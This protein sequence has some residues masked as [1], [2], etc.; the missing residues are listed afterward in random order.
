V[1]GLAGTSVRLRDDAG[2]ETVVLLAN[3]LAHPDLE[4]TGGQAHLHVEPLGGLDAL[5]AEVR[6]GIG[7]GTSLGGGWGMNWGRV[8]TAAFVAAIL[9]TAVACQP[10]AT[11]GWR[12]ELVSV[13][14]AGTGTGNGDSTDPVFSPDGTK[15]AFVSYATDLG[16]E[17]VTRFVT[18]IYVRDLTSNEVTLVSVSAAGDD[19]GNG[20]STDPVFS[21]D[22]TKIA[23]VSVARNLGPA[24]SDRPGD[25]WDQD[26]YVRDLEAGTTTLASVNTDGTDSGAFRSIDPVFNPANG[27][28]LVF[29]SGADDLVPDDGDGYN[30]DIFLRDLSAG[31]TTLLTVNVPDLNVGDGPSSDPAF[32]G[33]GSKLAFQSGANLVPGF[34]RSPGPDVF[35]RDMRTGVTTPVSW[36][37]DHTRGANASSERPVL[38][39]DGSMVAFTSSATD[40]AGGDEDAPSGAQ[41][42]IFVRDLTT[43]TTTLASVGEQYHAD[44]ATFS[45]DGTKLAYTSGVVSI[46]RTEEGLIAT[47][48]PDV[49]DSLENPTFSPDSR[50]LLARTRSS[51]DPRES[52]FP[53]N[54]VY[55]IDLGNGHA[56]LI[57]SNDTQTEGGDD[58]SGRWL[59]PSVFSPD[60]RSIAFESWAGDLTADADNATADIYITRFVEAF[61]HADLSLDATASDHGGALRPALRRLDR[62]PALRC[63]HPPARR[64]GAAH[65]RRPRGRRPRHHTDQRGRHRPRSDAR[66]CGRQQRRGHERRGRRLSRRRP[67][68]VHGYGARR[69]SLALDDG[70]ARPW[71]PR[72][73]LPT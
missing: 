67:R 59:E 72:T 15:M 39:A 28:E 11:Q 19:G 48:V 70:Q 65:G 69:A 68:G 30:D 10:K 24:D 61:D 36:N 31:T 71:R 9:G 41:R 16:P 12:S 38:D 25:G 34:L 22:G 47:P 45:P 17:V 63:G 26:I 60:G 29:T 8:M 35:V 66:P 7:S 20:D 46:E 49:P 27:N 3:L 54:D 4:L 42:D 40:L 5:P 2:G 44:L 1:V 50:D 52:D 55:L 18:N 23:F 33:D 43:E 13:N 51:L 32:S 14:E 56:Q 58:S 64:F 73:Q 37:A 57:S 53:D 6:G 21:P 62:D